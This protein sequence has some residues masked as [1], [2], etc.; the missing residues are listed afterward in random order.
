MSKS[1]IQL[2]VCLGFLF[3]LPVSASAQLEIKAGPEVYY[4]N[5]EEPGIMKESGI[6]YGA[7]GSLKYEHKNKML[8]LEGRYA[9]GAVDYKSENSGSINNVDNYVTE[10]RILGGQSFSLTESSTVTPYVGWGFRELHIEGTGRT[11][12]TG[13]F[14]YD[15]ISNYQYSPIGIRTNSELKN[16]WSIGTTIEYD[17]FWRGKQKSQWGD[18]NSRYKNIENIQEEG[19]GAR[20]SINLRRKFQGFSLGIEPFIRS[21]FIEKSNLAY[22][23]QSY[24][25]EPSNLTLE[26]GAAVT[27]GF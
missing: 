13:H 3:A 4:F 14:Y 16:G 17:F 10:W 24:L 18:A 6:M 7:A 23:G 5:Y 20:I 8:Q 12:T 22:N 11:S 19:H 26:I 21:W 25:K 15:R 1:Q 27:L 9:S 2:F